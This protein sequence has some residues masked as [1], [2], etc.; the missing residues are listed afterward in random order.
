MMTEVRVPVLLNCIFLIFLSLP[1]RADIP[2]P[3]ETPVPAEAPAAVKPAPPPVAAAAGGDRSDRLAAELIEASSLKQLPQSYIALVKNTMA[4]RK[5]SAEC[6]KSEECL[7][8]IT[9]FETRTLQEQTQ[10][11][12]EINRRL[13][14][15]LAKK[16]T[17]KELEVLIKIQKHSV[18]ARFNDFL[19][20]DESF[21]PIDD[22]LDIIK[23][24]MPPVPPAAG[25]D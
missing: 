5:N 20:S 18:I 19:N 12:A 13:R 4:R 3:T 11:I 15:I 24:H 17:A 25:A 1:A 21:K 7:R 9:E 16:F 8:Q 10:H 22:E 14:E 6:K 2:A 23:A